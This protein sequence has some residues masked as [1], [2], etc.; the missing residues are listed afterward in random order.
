VTAGGRQLLPARSKFQLQIEDLDVT[1][2]TTLFFFAPFNIYIRDKQDLVEL[3]SICL[4]LSIQI[5]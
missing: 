2:V 1:I 5:I 3:G 4:A